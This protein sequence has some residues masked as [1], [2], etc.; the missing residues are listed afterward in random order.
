MQGN[1]ENSHKP[2]AAA[3][4]LDKLQHVVEQLLGPQG[5]PWDKE[6]TPVSL[7]EYIIEECFEL[8]DA[9]R[10]GDDKN[11][12]NELGDVLFLLIF[13]AKLHA[14][15]NSSDLATSLDNVAAK[16]IRR[17][18]HVFS[19]AKYNNKAELIEN[20]NNIKL[21]EQKD[22][23][24]EEGLLSGLPQGLP[25][26]TRA[27]RIH[28]K[29]AATGFTWPEDEEVE[30]QVEAEWLE[31]LDAKA[32]GND[33]AFEHEYGDHLFTLVELGRRKGIKA[34]I[35]LDNAAQR[36]LR[37]FA[38]M[39]QIARS[40]GLDFKALPLDEKDTLWN[41]AKSKEQA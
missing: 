2:S 18:P 31:L 25:P 38:L 34:A 5:C 13:L 11:I 39:E 3:L 15:K 41:E 40:R 29:A 36:F 30:M 8:V 17:H 24:S 9:I 1:A 28:A 10:S 20:W 4:A 16:M 19:D 35:A 7:T 14:R 21:A 32:S 37:R 26:L 27:Y 12:G 6:Q 22:S 23:Q 33:A